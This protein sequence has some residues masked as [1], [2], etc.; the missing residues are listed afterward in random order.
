MIQIDFNTRQPESGSELILHPDIKDRLIQAVKT[1]LMDQ[2][3]G[4]K[5]S[6]AIIDVSITL[7]DDHHIAKL[8]EQ[9]RQKTGSTNVLSFAANDMNAPDTIAHIKQFLTDEKAGRILPLGDIVLSWPAVMRQASNQDKSASDHATHLVIHAL[10]H[11]LG[12]HHDDE[13]SRL[14]MESLE[15]RL[16][17][18]LN[19]DNPYLIPK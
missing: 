18:K 6:D 4:I 19:I 2:I 16:C 9:H 13:N 14:A 7:C 1:P 10:L 15:I 8:N 3:P 5:T 17:N 12:Y 11:L